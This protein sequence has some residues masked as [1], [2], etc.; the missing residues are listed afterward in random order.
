MSITATT[1]LEAVITLIRTRLSSLFTLDPNTATPVNRV[2]V[3]DK[4]RLQDAAVPNLQI[5]PLSLAAIA[6][7][8]SMNVMSFEYRVHAVVKVELD[9]GQ[10]AEKRMVGNTPVGEN[11]P[12]GAFTWAV[13]VADRLIG[14]KPNNGSDA[15][16]FLRLESGQSDDVEGLAS[17]SA[18]FRT[19]VRL[20]T[21]G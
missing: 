7:Y 16:V 10:R 19:M 4:L 5:E 11:Y 12:K 20:M 21:D 1:S 3:V 15:Q 6:E 17:A 2:F 13:A 18:H 14:Y 8:S 9:Q